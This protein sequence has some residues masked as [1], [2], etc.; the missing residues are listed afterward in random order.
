MAEIPKELRAIIDANIPFNSSRRVVHRSC[1]QGKNPALSVKRLRE[2]YVFN[3]F[4]CG[5]KGF[6]G[7]QKLPSHQILDMVKSISIKPHAE[8]EEIKL[9]DDAQPMMESELSSPIISPE[10]NIIPMEAYFWLWDAGIVDNL[11]E[12]YDFHWAESYKRVI[13]PIKDEFNVLEGFLA[14]DV[15]YSKGAKYGDKYI[16]RKQEGLGR[17]IYFRCHSKNTSRVVI[18]EDPLSAIRVHEATGYETVALLNTHIGSDLFRE[19]GAYKVT[20]WLDDGQL[21]NMITTVA[22]AQTYG[23]KCSHLN[24][25]KD[26]KYYDDNAIKNLFKGRT[27]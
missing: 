11:I 10:K 13:V 25:T 1:S 3:C 16:L 20:I 14:R 2:G 18:V 15:F 24:T 8:M 22:R 4:R 19:Y 6:I 26:P 23:I 17:R 27:K 12:K 7:G 21:A 5:F 9:P